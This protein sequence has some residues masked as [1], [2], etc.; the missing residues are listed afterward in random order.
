MSDDHNKKAKEPY[1]ESRHS[2]GLFNRL[3]LNP[4]ATKRIEKYGYTT[5]EFK[6]L[7]SRAVSY[8]KTL[9]YEDCFVV[10]RDEVDSLPEPEWE[11]FTLADG[12]VA[13]IFE[14]TPIS[15]TGT[16]V[17]NFNIILDKIEQ[18][19]LDLKL[20]GL[21]CQVITINDSQVSSVIKDYLEDSRSYMSDPKLDRSLQD[22]ANQ[23]ASEAS[24]R[25]TTLAERGN[26]SSRRI[27]LT[28][29][30]SPSSRQNGPKL[31]KAKLPSWLS[32]LKSSKASDADTAQQYREEWQSMIAR[33][34]VA[35]QQF[36]SVFVGH[37]SDANGSVSNLRALSL[38]DFIDLMF[39][40]FNP[41]L[42]RAQMESNIARLQN[43]EE[44]I[45]YLPYHSHG[46]TMW[47]AQSDIRSAIIQTPPKVYGDH[48]EFG[49][50][51][52]TP[53]SARTIPPYASFLDV[54]DLIN[55]TLATDYIFTINFHPISRDMERRI[56]EYKL[57]R[58]KTDISLD[59]EKA[60]RPGGGFQGQTAAT[61][62]KI[63]EEQYQTTLRR[64]ASKEHL[65][66][67]TFGLS[68]LTND[69]NVLRRELEKLKEF[70]RAAK[71]GPIVEETAAPYVLRDMFPFCHYPPIDQ[72][73]GRTLKVF[74]NDLAN[75]L[76]I[77]GR[78]EPGAGRA[79]MYPSGE[80]GLV[81]YDMFDDAVAPS[82]HWF[83]VGKSGTG[84]SFLVNSIILQYLR[85]NPY[86]YIID[87]GGSYEKM[88]DIFVGSSEYIALDMND[89]NLC[90]NPM[91]IKPQDRDEFGV[92]ETLDGRKFQLVNDEGYKVNVI[93]DPLTDGT[94]QIKFN[95]EVDKNINPA[96]VDSATH[97]VLIGE[98]TIGTINQTGDIDTPDGKIIIMASD[99]KLSGLRLEFFKAVA[100]EMISEGKT[101][102]EAN[103]LEIN[104]MSQAIISVFEN[105][106]SQ[107]Y[108]LVSDIIDE[109]RRQEGGAPVYPNGNDVSLKIQN[110]SL[111]YKGEYGLLFDRPPTISL[112]KKIIVFEMQGV[113]N[114]NCKTPIMLSIMNL[115]RNNVMADDKRG[116]RKLL[117]MDEAW[118]MIGKS[119][120]MTAFVEKAYRE[121]RKYNCSVGCISQ[122]VDDLEGVASGA[123]I[124]NSATKWFLRHDDT[125]GQGAAAIVKELTP[126][127]LK[128]MKELQMVPGQFGECLLKT[129]MKGSVIVRIMPSPRQN[130]VSTTKSSEVKLWKK[131]LLEKGSPSEALEYLATK[132]PNGLDK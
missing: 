114:A 110:Y 24:S 66:K 100:A 76:P 63:L 53:V 13:K 115:I 80:G 6:S 45:D 87:L 56:F 75:Q 132:Y 47:D 2:A 28:I 95:P 90:V 48:V 16:S 96:L 92:G 22:I 11:V 17:D 128:A 27:Y 106:R 1:F 62:R 125:N 44:A 122:L 51:R 7:S 73:V 84:K 54:W 107:T 59:E 9:P 52:Y 77:A 20:A 69:D 129:E 15:Y 3:L 91:V 67:M 31:G 8:S 72:F 49:N 57:N 40:I 105:D 131:T 14:I 123:L 99:K 109:L 41:E 39:S 34:V 32:W 81:T 70:F 74:S 71:Y 121:F 33:L 65:L 55:N 104:Q 97:Q 46:C 93:L 10:T 108:L 124:K 50:Y 42:Y 64:F 116:C 88:T 19:F 119:E 78:W 4:H 112:N 111:K 98:E 113:I 37:K 36:K 89:P 117:V 21:T 79:L 61:A 102:D 68:L 25:I 5:E 85:Y 58:L 83:V 35:T 101:S 18:A 30:V 82:P 23:F 118:Q 43:G 103:K 130:W 26:V 126:E 60:S 29:V 127:D 86:L 38:I 12:A 94:K 120:A